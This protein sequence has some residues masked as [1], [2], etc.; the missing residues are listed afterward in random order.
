MYM[1]QKKMNS[2]WLTIYKNGIVKGFHQGNGDN[3]IKNI[4]TTDQ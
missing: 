1:L 2:F 3:L 4:K